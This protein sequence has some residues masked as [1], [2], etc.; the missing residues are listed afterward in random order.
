MLLIFLPGHSSPN[1]CVLTPC[2]L[3]ERIWIGARSFGQQWIKLLPSR[4]DATIAVLRPTAWM[5][6]VK[7][8]Q[9]PNEIFTANYLSFIR[10]DVRESTPPSAP[11]TTSNEEEFIHRHQFSDFSHKIRAIQ[12]INRSEW[13]DFGHRWWS[14]PNSGQTIFSYFVAVVGR[15]LFNGLHLSWLEDVML[16]NCSATWTLCGVFLYVYCSNQ[17]DFGSFNWAQTILAL[18]PLFRIH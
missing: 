14:S 15:L 7:Q 6:C 3:S 11:A 12:V 9:R 4:L 10:T 5:W 18:I 1:V 2:W 16:W 8:Q 17:A 13:I